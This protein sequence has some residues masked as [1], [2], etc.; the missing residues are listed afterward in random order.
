M[1][2]P[3]AFITRFAPSPSGELHLGHAFAALEARRL[4][5]EHGGEMRLRIEDIDRGR[6]APHFVTA[7]YEDL[8]YLGVTWDGPVQVQSERMD[9]Y[10]QALEQLKQ[11]GLV[12]PCHLTRR[13][14]DQL[15]S[16]PQS[17]PPQAEARLATRNTDRLIPSGDS[18]YEPEPGDQPA[19]RLRMDAIETLLTGLEYTDL[20]FGT[21]AVDFTRLGDEVIARKDVATSY[22]L[23]VVL[24]DADA[25]VTVVTRSE[26]LLS[27]TP[28]HR[29]LQALLGLPE[30]RWWHHPLVTDEQGRRLA[31]RDGDRAIRQYRKAGMSRADLLDQLAKGNFSSSYS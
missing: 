24:D 3:T 10:Q 17:S 14:L 29:V 16:A 21:Q 20:R 11:E 23:S 7:I 5:D 12:Y 31:K 19:W 2:D 1:T 28:L 26:D 27:A 13:Q 30:P 22:H 6:C 25:G 9:V 15:L 4:A 8:D 18:T